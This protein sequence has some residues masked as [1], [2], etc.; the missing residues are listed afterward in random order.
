MAIS[1]KVNASKE[2]E[3]CLQDTLAFAQV[4]SSCAFQCI[5]AASTT[6]A[7]IKKC[8]VQKERS[9]H[10]AFTSLSLKGFRQVLVIAQCYRTQQ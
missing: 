2:E 3:A 5:F 9:N 6:K 1:W 7:K 4:I 10:Q 8:Q